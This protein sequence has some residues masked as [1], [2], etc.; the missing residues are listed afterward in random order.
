M[1]SERSDVF[2]RMRLLRKRQVDERTDRI[3]DYGD[4]RAMTRRRGWLVR[5]LL[6]ASD[7]TALLGAFALVQFA[8]GVEQPEPGRASLLTE[9]ALF[10]ATLPAWV[11][12]LRAYG[13]YEHDEERTNHST[14]DDLVGVF[15]AVTLGA[16]TFFAL[17]W[18]TGVASPQIPKIVAFWGVG[19]MLLLVGR[20]AA[21][22][23]AR[24]QVAY[25]QNTVIVGAGHVGQTLARKLTHHTEY[26]LNLVGFVDS[27]P[28]DRAT[29]L[30]HL[31]MLCPPDQ[32]PELVTALDIERVIVA[33][34]ANG[35]SHL[36]T[37]KVIRALKDHD[38]QIDIVP[39]LFEVVGARAELH[40]L[41]GI[42][43]LGLPPLR[44][45][46]TSIALKRTIDVVLSGL[47]LLVLSPVFVVIALLIKRDAPGPVFFRQVR[48]GA[49]GKTFRIYKF[50]TMCTD[51]EERKSE[52]VSL[53]K[54][55]IAGRDARMFKARN[56]PRV[57]RVG[58]VLRRYAL[59]ELPQ[60]INVLKGEMSLVGPR[61]LI[62]E[63]ASHVSGWGS[64]RISLKPGITGPWQVLGASDI[65][66]EEMVQL[67]YLYVTGWTVFNDLK[68][69]LRTLPAVARVRD[70]Y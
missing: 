18:L 22:A 65:P 2:E 42:P 37:L 3:V 66:F 49:R 4:G 61:P 60:L 19:I 13:L 62:L 33:F 5:R 34:S 38:V 24:R 10:L 11:L 57:T 56:D 45:S 47:G 31:S 40:S 63:E 51:A 39:R 1:N 55:A 20:A 25:L 53:N 26:G 12:L 52:I 9:V 17:T 44:L 70:A 41:G 15:H 48:M 64:S 23:V 29:D 58:R 35:H 36:D 67:D 54:H 43:M 30:E 50:R 28:I 14:A 6:A 59:D 32:L 16:W 27:K 21:R 7:L 69:L 46:R 8:F 68:L